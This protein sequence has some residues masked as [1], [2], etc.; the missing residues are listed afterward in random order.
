MLSY[1]H[2]FVEER[3]LPFL[4]A[5]TA[6]IVWDMIPSDFLHRM[7]TLTYRQNVCVSK[8]SLR[9]SRALDV[10]KDLTERILCNPFLG[11]A[12]LHNLSLME[13]AEETAPFF[14]CDARAFLWPKNAVFHTRAFYHAALFI[15]NQGKEVRDC[16]ESGMVGTWGQIRATKLL[17]MET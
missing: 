9:Y 12:V 11:V 15:L 5:K 10:V 8:V 1:L 16:P 13:Y 7:S 6:D 17:L 2:K 4:I 14:V 3:A